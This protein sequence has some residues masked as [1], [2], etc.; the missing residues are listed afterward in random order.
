MITRQNKAT[1]E[2]GSTARP[3]NTTTNVTP[4]TSS[5]GA[6]VVRRRQQQNVGAALR[7][8]VTPSPRQFTPTTRSQSVHTEVKNNTL[9]PSTSE[10]S[11]LC[12]KCKSPI[13]KSDKLTIQCDICQSLLHQFCTAIPI[14]TFEKL[15]SIVE[16]TGWVCENCKSAARSTIAQTQAAVSTVVEQIA[17]M[18]LSIDE[19]KAANQFTSSEP[20]PDSPGQHQPSNV[21]SETVMIVHRTLN[22]VNRRRKNVIVSGLSESSDDKQTFIKICDDFLNVKP[23]LSERTCV[24]IGPKRPDRPRLLLVRLRSE[25]AATE[26]LRVA[27]RL[28]HCHDRVYINPDLAPEAAKI[29]FEKRRER[30]ARRVSEESGREGSDAIEIERQRRTTDTTTTDNDIENVTSPA[31]RPAA[32]DADT[33]DTAAAAAAVTL[34]PGAR[35]GGVPSAGRPI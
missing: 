24:R 17:D 22:D 26:I 18:K 20:S 12:Q 34:S 16:S 30:R 1:A 23:S 8:S 28:R 33:D 5:G 2:A 10:L 21:K 14:K 13:S 4:T 6:V 35:G 31:N 27:P 29:A 32:A 19:L 11:L 9:I 25:E 7:P 15:K 3:T